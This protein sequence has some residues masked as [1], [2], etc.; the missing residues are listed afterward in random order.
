[1]RGNPGQAIF[2]ILPSGEKGEKGV[3]KGEW[4]KG[5]KRC[6]ERVKKLK[7]AEFY[8]LYIA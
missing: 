5:G 4:K 2:P 7:H 8:K 3:E 6:Q 1:V